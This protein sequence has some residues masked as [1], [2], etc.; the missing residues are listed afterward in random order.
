MAARGAAFLLGRLGCVGSGGI[1]IGWLGAS[2]KIR[3]GKAESFMEVSVYWSRALVLISHTFSWR[4]TPPQMT[5][6]PPSSSVPTFL[7]QNP[8]GEQL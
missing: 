4:E 5:F 2:M 3:I 7:Y 8:T 1:I 6:Q